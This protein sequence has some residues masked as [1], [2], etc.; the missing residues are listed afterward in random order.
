MQYGI[1]VIRSSSRLS[2]AHKS[3]TSQVTQSI[4]CDYVTFTTLESYLCDLLD[5][6][7][8]KLPVN[9]SI[10]VLRVLDQNLNS[11]CE[12]MVIHISDL[13]VLTPEI[14]GFFGSTVHLDSVDRGSCVLGNLPHQVKV[15]PNVQ[16]SSAQLTSVW[17]A[18][19]YYWLIFKVLIKT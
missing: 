1:S 19:R 4:P 18:S 12:G 2:K 3:M 14:P 13:L 17:S 15:D 6:S 10:A 5:S 8:D 9:E 7:F 11:S 16:W